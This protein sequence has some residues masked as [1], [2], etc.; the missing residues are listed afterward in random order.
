MYHNA[1][2][3]KCLQQ[4]HGALVGGSILQGVWNCI[5][6][7]LGGKSKRSWQSVLECYT[8][9]PISFFLLPC[10][11][12]TNNFCHTHPSP[13]CVHH[14]S[15]NT[16]PENHILDPL[17]VWKLT[18]SPLFS[19]ALGSHLCNSVD[20]NVKPIVSSNSI[21]EWKEVSSP[22]RKL[23][24]SGWREMNISLR[25]PLSSFLSLSSN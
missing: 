17:K 2:H 19:W 20:I 25:C 10:H 8:C 15:R 24:H 9:T 23:W 7:G 11:Q 12:E 21:R 18:L 5:W 22:Q 1:L 6:C 16:K 4:A 3:M 14:R 13:W